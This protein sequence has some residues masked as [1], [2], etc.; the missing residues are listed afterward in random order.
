MTLT[1]KY[2]ST[3]ENGWNGLMVWM[4][5]RTDEEYTWY[6]YDLTKVATNAMLKL[7]PEKIDPLGVHGYSTSDTSE[8]GA[9]E[10][11]N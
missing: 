5:P 7:I 9:E 6:R 10:S 2:K 1:E 8:S 3:Y 4:E 11:G